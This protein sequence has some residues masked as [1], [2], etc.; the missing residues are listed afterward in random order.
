MWT[1]FALRRKSA[2]LCRGDDAAEDEPESE[3]CEGV[4]DFTAEKLGVVQ[5]ND[6]HANS[7]QAEQHPR[8]PWGTWLSADLSNGLNRGPR[9]VW[10]CALR[11]YTATLN[12]TLLG[13]RHTRQSRPARRKLE[14]RVYLIG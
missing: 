5:E 1:D 13:T 12:S 8:N 10:L 6:Q 3:Q 7:E 11:G 2:Q 14:K 9:V 4:V